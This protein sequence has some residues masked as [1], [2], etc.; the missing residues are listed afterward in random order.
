MD[1]DTF[2]SGSR[3]DRSSMGL[4]LDTSAKTIGVWNSIFAPIPVG[5]IRMFVIHIQLPNT[6]S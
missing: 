3:W 6:P 1:T 5:T 4:L 2:P